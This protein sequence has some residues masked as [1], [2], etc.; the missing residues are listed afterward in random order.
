MDEIV[1]ISDTE[2]ENAET[3]NKYTTKMSGT[4]STCKSDSI[5]YVDFNQIIQSSSSM[6]NVNEVP[7]LMLSNSSSSLPDTQVVTL[8]CKK[9]LLP[10]SYVTSNSLNP[11]ELHELQIGNSKKV[12]LLNIGKRSILPANEA[13][14][15]ISTPELVPLSA[16]SLTSVPPLTAFSGQT[17]IPLISYAPLSNSV[18]PSTLIL[19]KPVQYPICY[20]PTP[21][22]TTDIR[23][24][25]SVCL[26]M[27]RKAR[28]IDWEGF[29]AT[30]RLGFC[31]SDGNRSMRCL[32]IL[33]MHIS[34]REGH[35]AKLRPRLKNDK[36]NTPKDDAPVIQGNKKGLVK[37]DQFKATADIEVAKVRK[38]SRPKAAMSTYSLPKR[39]RT[40]RTKVK[41]CTHNIKL[42]DESA[43]FH[44]IKICTAED[45]CCPFQCVQLPLNYKKVTYPELVQSKNYSNTYYVDPTNVHDVDS[46]K[47][48]EPSSS[49]YFINEHDTITDHYMESIPSLR[50]KV[51]IIDKFV[52]DTYKNL[53]PVKKISEKGTLKKKKIFNQF[54]TNYH[55][56]QANL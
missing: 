28:K 32:R 26:Q 12:F 29:S 2:E 45:A 54:V 30:D 14:K 27:K 8:Q 10:A 7:Q 39:I 41:K 3:S 38:K 4:V 51:K 1:V 23:D 47:K 53:R 17:P 46:I 20:V 55:N 18:C 9:L 43:R 19:P 13:A 21:G 5:Q 24:V 16:P 35:L 44:E 36:S 49:I 50:S 52:Y 33:N 6:P 40:K 11:L 15:E 34:I 31:V 22:K 25:N 48:M 56:R 42:C 37:F